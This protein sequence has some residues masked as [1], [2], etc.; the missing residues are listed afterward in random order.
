MLP[1]P[2]RGF[3]YAPAAEAVAMKPTWKLPP[4]A[5]LTGPPLAVQ[6]RSLLTIAQ[7]MVPGPV[8]PIGFETVGGP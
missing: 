7:V 6:V 5:M 4:R 8:M 2:A 1:T 3:A